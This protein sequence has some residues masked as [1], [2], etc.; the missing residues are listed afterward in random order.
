MAEL[1]FRAVIRPQRAERLCLELL[2]RPWIRE[3]HAIE[4]EGSGTQD[5]S[6]RDPDAAKT[7]DVLPRVLVTG[8]V[9]EEGREEMVDLVC[10]ICRANRS[11][12]GKVFFLHPERV[13][14]Y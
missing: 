14:E 7:I 3:L 8:L 13:I 11:G 6:A 1:Y 10:S 12:D 4:I 5:D 9:D 2:N